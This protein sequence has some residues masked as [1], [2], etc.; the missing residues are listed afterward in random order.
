MEI[1]QVTPCSNRVIW[2]KSQEVKDWLAKARVPDYKITLAGDS[3]WIESPH[4]Y[5][6]VLPGEW[7]LVSN[8]VITKVSVFA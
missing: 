3:L 4:A 5:Y 6:E 1:V 2:D 7:V 8:T